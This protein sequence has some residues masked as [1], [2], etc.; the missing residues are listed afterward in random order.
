MHL[1]RRILKNTK[2][3]DGLRLIAYKQFFDSFCPEIGVAH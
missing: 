2:G 1:K 3:M